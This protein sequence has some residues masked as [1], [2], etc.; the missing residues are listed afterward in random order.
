[1]YSRNSSPAFCAAV[2][3]AFNAW[4]A[5]KYGGRVRTATPCKPPRPPPPPQLAAAAAAAAEAMGGGKRA[6]GGR[7]FPG[8]T[9]AAA[10]PSDEEVSPSNLMKAK[11][12]RRAR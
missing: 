1:M 5:S 7:L 8:T 6:R 2:H 9:E 4:L 11:Q 10:A 12:A 3:E